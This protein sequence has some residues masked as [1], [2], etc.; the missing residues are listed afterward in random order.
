LLTVEVERELPLA[1]AAD[2]QR[3]SQDGHV[4]GKLVLSV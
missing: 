3:L 2:A 1:E 4:R